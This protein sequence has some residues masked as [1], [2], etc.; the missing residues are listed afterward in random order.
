MLTRVNLPRR[1]YNFVK[2]WC[3]ILHGDV[4]ISNVLVSEGKAIL[5]EFSMSVE[6]NWGFEK[7]VLDFGITIAEILNGRRYHHAMFRIIKSHPPMKVWTSPLGGCYRTLWDVARWCWNSDSY[8]R[9]TMEDVL[10]DLSGTRQLPQHFQPSLDRVDTDPIPSTG[11]RRARPF[12]DPVADRSPTVPRCLTRSRSRTSL[13]PDGGPKMQCIMLPG[14][15]PL[16]YRRAQGSPPARGG[17]SEV[18]M[19]EAV[20]PENCRKLL[21]EKVLGGVDQLDQLERDGSAVL[22]KRLKQEVTIWMKLNHRNIAPLMGFTLF[23]SVTLIAPWYAN[24]NIHGYLRKQPETNRMKLLLE[25][26]SGL[27]YLHEFEPPVVHGD[28][29]PDNILID[30]YGSAVIND[31]GLSRSVGETVSALISSRRGAGNVRWMAP[32]L[33]DGSIPKSLEGDVYSFAC[34]AFFILTGLIP[35]KTLSK[36]PPIVLALCAGHTPVAP[37]DRSRSLNCRPVPEQWVWPLL[38]E[39]WEKQPDKRPSMRRIQERLARMYEMSV[40]SVGQSGGMYEIPE[41]VESGDEQ[42]SDRAEN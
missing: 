25:I 36:D 9:P 1:S 40:G 33:L 28:I 27:A 17:Y 3:P 37:S 10:K 20:G 30:D 38:D 5:Y 19:C 22:R 29:K 18:W 41:G 35:F 4:G 16:R 7:D 12:S 6:Q 14:C 31:F 39:C 15:P 13:P 26:A 34:L 23:P 8:R 2:R 11:R 21:A 32:E 42:G 24:G